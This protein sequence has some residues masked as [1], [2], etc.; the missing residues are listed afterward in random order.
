MSA[1]HTRDFRHERRLSR[2]RRRPHRRWLRGC[3]WGV[4]VIVLAVALGGM[5]ALSGRDYAPVLTG[6]DHDRVSAEVEEVKHKVEQVR[7]DAAAGVRRDFRLAVTDEQLN[8]LLSEDAEVR[9]RLA[10]RNVEES[11]VSIG[12][13]QMSAT[14]IR[15]VGGVNVQVRATLVPELDGERSVR[16]RIISLR[17]GRF[18]APASTA[19]RLADE[20]GRLISSQVTDS[21]AKITGVKLNGN[22]VELTGTTG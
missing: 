19:Q 12:E 20:I 16:A 14:A 5:F 17:I 7:K 4:V 3:L 13:G 2:R 21:R 9:R 11:W 1:P 18:A 10:E 22:S 15:S 6:A 8:L